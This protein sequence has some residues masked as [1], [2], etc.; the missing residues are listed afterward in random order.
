MPEYG[1]RQRALLEIIEGDAYLAVNDEGADPATIRYLTGFTGEGALLVSGRETVLLTDSRY[2]EQAKGET[3]AVSI[4]E[5]KAWRSKATAE[6]ICAR[7]LERVVFPSTRATF[8]WVEE[9]RKLGGFTLV[10]EKDPVAVLRRTKSPAEVDCLKK[11]AAI[12]DEAFAS[13][14]SELRVGM[15]EAEVALR[16]EVLIRETDAEG[17]AFS[18]NASAGANTTLNHYNP[19]LAPRPLTE[20]DLLLFD[21]GACYGGYRSD[22]TRT[23]SVGRPQAKARE[24][25]D[26]VLR[27]NLAAIEV[28]RAGKTGS[29]IDAVARDLISEAGF[30][31]F[32]GHGLGHG[33]GLEVH[34][35]P[36]LN[37]Q[38]ND[39][40]EVGMVVTIEPGIYLPGFGGVR[41]EDD[42]VVGPDGCEVITGFPK[43]RLVE[44][45][46]RK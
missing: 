41:I 15:S 7:G 13:L 29:E 12:A 32:F 28:V 11:A 40:L 18:V 35:A 8:F 45:G 9:M 33:I 25:Y 22:I 30:A 34:E 1:N 10:P 14:I 39:P 6:A 21:F 5:G 24:I 3:E 26:I 44:V 43:D 31:S 16:L 2:T 46:W 19:S 37:S 4:E 38:S 17:I 27:A 42:V 23:V 20:G 36:G